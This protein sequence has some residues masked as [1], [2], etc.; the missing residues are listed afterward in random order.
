MYIRNGEIKIA[1]RFAPPLSGYSQVAI[2]IYIVSN[3][4]RILRPNEPNPGFIFCRFSSFV[5]ERQNFQVNETL[6]VNLSSKSQYNADCLQFQIDRPKEN[7]LILVCWTN[8]TLSCISL[9][10]FRDFTAKKL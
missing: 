7:L 1:S 5:N 8:T 9:F 3:P 10:L 6:A 4:F 2:I